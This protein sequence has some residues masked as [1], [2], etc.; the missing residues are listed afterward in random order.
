MN[1]YA[2][3]TGHANDM[4]YCAGG[5]PTVTPGTGWIDNQLTILGLGRDI[6][7][8]NAL[9]NYIYLTCQAGSYCNDNYRFLIFDGG[10]RMTFNPPQY[11]LTVTKA[12]TGSGTVTSVP[13]GI[14]CGSTC[15]ANYNS[16]ISVTV[17]ASPVSDS[18]FSGWS[19][20]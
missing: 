13:A 5:S 2:C 1:I 7:P 18:V 17:T 6:S 9:L 11:L 15:S 14:N 20:G 19:G 8:T 16:G 4:N 3:Q 12:G 10:F